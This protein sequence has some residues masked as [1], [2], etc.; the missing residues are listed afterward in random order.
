MAS[1][2]IYSLNRYVLFVQLFPLIINSLLIYFEGYLCAAATMGIGHK[3]I[4]EKKVCNLDI[5]VFGYMRRSRS[6]CASRK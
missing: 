3:G 1:V 4:S 6:H 5:S 2:L